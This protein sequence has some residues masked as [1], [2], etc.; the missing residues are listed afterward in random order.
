VSAVFVRAAALAS[1]LGPDL[2][3]A[4]ERLAGAPL[5]PAPCIEAGGRWPYFA[6]PVPA[7]RWGARAEQLARGVAEDLRRKAALSAGEWQGLPCFVGSSSHDVGACESAA[8]PKLRP[9]LELARSLAQWFGVRG[10]TIAVSSACTSGLTALQLALDL[11]A[12]GAF[13]HALV[14]GVELANRLTVAGFAGLGLLSPRAARPCDRNRDGL[15]L[16]EALGAVLLSAS[17]AWR[18]GSLAW[19]MDASSLTG[20]APDGEVVRQTMQTALLRARWTAPG[21][22]LVK[23]QAAGSPAGDLSEARAL[24][25]LFP[26]PP[27]TVSLKSAIGHALGA[28]GPAELAL[29]LGALDRG[30]V[31]ATWGFATPD[32][33]LGL[34]PSGGD[35]GAVR[36]VLFN[37]SG[38]GGNVCSM[39]LERPG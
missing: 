23:L 1:A 15:V 7:G 25:A 28:S 36:R 13:R 24:R 29:L 26:D 8:D 32:A 3:T 9:P 11:I 2:D 31:P 33:E 12:A 30:R 22:D 17:G 27:R 10:P 14:L 5:V 4:L 6:I 20:S 35:A 38:F 19:G 21:V 18:V 37:L 16:G 39:A 34:A